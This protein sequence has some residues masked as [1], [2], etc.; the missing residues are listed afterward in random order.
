M[1]TQNYETLI[2][3]KVT[4]PQ[5]SKSNKFSTESTPAEADIQDLV[6]FLTK[7]CGREALYS[8]G[9]ESLMIKDTSLVKDTFKAL[10]DFRRIKD[11]HGLRKFLINHWKTLKVPKSR[12]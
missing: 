8:S 12:L 3:E 10:E 1:I 2:S 6:N 7:R 4:F 11:E 9:I 5:S